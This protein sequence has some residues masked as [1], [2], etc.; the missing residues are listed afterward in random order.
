M[1][2]PPQPADWWW[3][4]HKVS[5][6]GIYTK[7]SGPETGSGRDKLS[8]VDRKANVDV[9]HSVSTDDYF[10][11]LGAGRRLGG[12]VPAKLTEGLRADKKKAQD[13]I[14]LTLD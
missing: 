10:K 11:S 4:S 1:N 14:D 13:I 9:K 5:C 6:G 8:A 7:I 12:E 3:K 2:R